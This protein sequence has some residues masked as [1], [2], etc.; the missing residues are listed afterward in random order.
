V[1]LFG[2]VITHEDHRSLPSSVRLS[3]NLFEPEDT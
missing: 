3:L 2:P 1:M